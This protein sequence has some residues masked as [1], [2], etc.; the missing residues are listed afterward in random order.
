[1]RSYLSIVAIAALTV[2][3]VAA[4]PT[5]TQVESA[6]KQI[7]G[8]WKLEFTTP[9][10]V[11]RTPMVLVGRQHQELVA[12]YVEKDKPE[13]FKKVR[14]EDDTLLL[15]FRPKERSE[16]EVTFKA[17]LQKENVCAGEATY[18]SDD[19]DAG[20][21]EFKGKRVSAS[22]FDETENWRLSFVTPDEQ[23]HKATVT[24]VAKK[25][26]LYGWY[27]SKDFDLPAL[28]LSKDGDNVVMSM[29]AKTKDGANV[30]VTFRG[31]VNGDRVKGQV[32]YDLEGDIGHFP[33]AGQ[34]RS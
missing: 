12:W 27:S 19:G 11:K 28:E 30:D 32:D 8:A 4:N 31:T 21:W 26:Q 33:F 10:D 7:V 2:P 1:M 16:I 29:T 25:D 20:S 3:V 6:A 23:Q 18:Q 5:A 22:D 34:R 17:K 9:D 13:S 24:V 14:M 15:T